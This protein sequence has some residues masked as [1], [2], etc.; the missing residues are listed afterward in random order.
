MSFSLTS[1]YLEVKPDRQFIKRKF[2]KKWRPAA[3]SFR[4][5]ATQLPVADYE[6]MRVLN[7]QTISWLNHEA[8]YKD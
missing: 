3:I 7:K 5:G 8:P 4:T 6:R 1:T 2:V